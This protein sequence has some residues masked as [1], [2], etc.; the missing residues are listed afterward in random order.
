MF[1]RPGQRCGA[2]HHAAKAG[3]GVDDRVAKPADAGVELCRP[4]FCHEEIACDHP[5][6]CG[7]QADFGCSSDEV[8][9][10]RTA[11]SV[12]QRKARR[13]ASGGESDDEH[14]HTIQPS[15]RVPP[16][17]E[18]WGADQFHGGPRHGSARVH[19]PLCG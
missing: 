15:S 17:K 2:Q 14:S 9:D 5:V 7:H 18:E 12:S 1:Q 4:G 13:P 6:T 8:A 3:M 10:A 16:V 11:E 19:H